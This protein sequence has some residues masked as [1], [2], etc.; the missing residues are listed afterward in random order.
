MSQSSKKLK[1]KHKFDSK[2]SLEEKMDMFNSIKDKK[3]RQ[4]VF[5]ALLDSS[6]P[7][8]KEFIRWLTHDVL[9]SIRKTG[10]YNFNNRKWLDNHIKEY[11]KHLADYKKDSIT[12]KRDLAI[13]KTR[14]AD[15][16]TELKA[17][18]KEYLTLKKIEANLSD[19]KSTLDEM[20]ITI[21]KAKNDFNN[22]HGG[23][24]IFPTEYV[25]DLNTISH[26]HKY[27][28]YKIKYLRLLDTLFQDT[29]F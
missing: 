27:L 2:T 19:I 7:S 9:P 18:E 14:I 25:D 4:K 21:K 3:E 12:N 15:I 13:S 16:K 6:D 22:Q 29:V 11:Q 23:S 28:K 20:K 8:D 17:A 26:H 5:D 10:E 1:S 24:N